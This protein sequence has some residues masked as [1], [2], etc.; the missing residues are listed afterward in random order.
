VTG[1]ITL[2]R[3][4]L[5]HAAVLTELHARCFEDVWS[6]QS[7]EEVLG[8]AGAF[9][10]IATPAAAPSA[11]IGF[12]LGRVAVDEAELI[13]LCTLPEWRRRGIAQALLTE[14]ERAAL[15]GGAQRMFLE[16][17]ETNQAAQALY[18]A[19]GFTAVGRRPDYYQ[20]PNHAP[21]AALVL[22]RPLRS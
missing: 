13:T 10:F 7:M 8:M 3:A 9:A 11:P 22:R 14:S 1:A 4:S 20:R 5:A 6:R 2:A 17:A 21:V 15:A 12:S 19:R 16:V 18:L